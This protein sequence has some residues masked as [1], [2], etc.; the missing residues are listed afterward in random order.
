MQD[1]SFMKKRDKLQLA[2]QN[3]YSME[4]MAGHGAEGRDVQYIGSIL[5][6]N[7]IYDYYEDSQGDFW[8]KNLFYLPDGTKVTEEE[9]LFPARR[10]RK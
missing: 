6:G 3:A 4:N 7:R 9:Y 1:H 2:R 10:R 5:E 8:Y